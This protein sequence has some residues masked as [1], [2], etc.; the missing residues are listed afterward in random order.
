MLATEGLEAVRR[1][2]LEN[3]VEI[4]IYL[5]SIEISMLVIATVVSC[6]LVCFIFS[7]II[8]LDASKE[9]AKTSIDTV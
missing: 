8:L 6:I 7:I 4:S 3:Q 2:A 9:F 5:I 1:H